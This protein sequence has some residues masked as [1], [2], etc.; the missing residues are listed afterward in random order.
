ME[1]QFVDEPLDQKPDIN[2]EYYISPYTKSK[3][4][5]H[6][7]KL[8]L[9]AK[10]NDECL[11]MIKKIVNNDPKEVGE[12]C[13]EGWT[14]LMIACRNGNIEIVKL[15]LDRS[16]IDININKQHNEGRTAL[17]LACRYGNINSNSNLKTVKLLS[18]HPGIDVNKQDNSGWT[19]LMWA[20]SY[21]ITDSN[22]EIFKL[23]LNHPDIDVNRQNN[24]KWTALTLACVYGNAD[25]DVET[26]KLLLDH[27]N[28]DIDMQN[29]NGGKAVI[30]KIRSC[31]NYKE[32]IC[33]IYIGR[34]YIRK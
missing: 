28:I 13:A 11:E 12:Y 31:E 29:N 26:V 23:L 22:I 21:G 4:L 32:H 19:A 15:L 17:M 18:S 3:G 34:Q 7:M 10:N 24:D 25:S 6:L 1:N 30:E 33:E 14:S 5:T 9:C 8:V 16:D 20:C 2:R 27:P